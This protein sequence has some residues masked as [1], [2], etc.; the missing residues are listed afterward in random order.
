MSRS[1]GNSW[2]TSC[3]SSDQRKIFKEEIREILEKKENKE[4][5]REK[6]ES[7]SRSGSVIWTPQPWEEAEATWNL[8]KELGVQFRVNKFEVVKF[9]LEMEKGKMNEESCKEFQRS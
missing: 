7:E 1:R 9:F 2:A 8:S 6:G 3:T 4:K 5:N